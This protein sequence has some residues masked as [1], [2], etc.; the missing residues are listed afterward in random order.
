MQSVS[1]QK[2]SRTLLL[3]SPGGGRGGSYLYLEGRSETETKKTPAC[4]K[5]FWARVQNLNH[6]VWGV[7]TRQWDKVPGDFFTLKLKTREISLETFEKY[8]IN[9]G[10]KFL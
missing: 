7:L 1:I 9:A 4:G 6:K 10:I 3:I 8:V 2:T 5:W